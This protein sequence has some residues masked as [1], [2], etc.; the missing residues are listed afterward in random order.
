MR[1]NAYLGASGQKSDRDIRSVDL[2][3]LWDEYT[4]TAWW[5]FRHILDVFMHNFHSISWAWPSTFWPWK[6]FLYSITWPVHRG[7]P[8]PHITIF[9]PQIIY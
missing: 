6:C 3:L 7:L 1:R 5:R 2:D 9:W 8:K 4:S